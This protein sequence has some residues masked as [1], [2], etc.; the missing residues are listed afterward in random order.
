MA[1]RKSLSLAA[2]TACLV[3]ALPL[4]AAPKKKAPAKKAEYTAGFIIS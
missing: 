1:L 2:L 4:S 3:V